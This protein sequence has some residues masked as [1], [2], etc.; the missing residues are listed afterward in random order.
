MNLL[1]MYPAIV[2]SP[3][4]VLSSDIG[5]QDTTIPVEDVSCFP[6]APNLA[7]IIDSNSAE[8]ILYTG[9]DSNSLIGVTRGFQGTAKSWSS[10][11]QIGRMFTAYDHDAFR[12]NLLSVGDTITSH[13]NDGELNSNGNQIKHVEVVSSSESETPTA[14]RIVFDTSLG[15]FL[16]GNGS[17]W[18]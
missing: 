18:V 16:G 8:T 2:N 9:K 1:E 10:G 17:E 15:K 13:I 4:T 3:T 7:V 12:S 11:T 14:G 5:D 6:D